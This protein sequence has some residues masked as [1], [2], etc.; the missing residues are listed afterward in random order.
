MNKDELMID[1]IAA[2]LGELSDAAISAASKALPQLTNGGFVNAVFA[3]GIT[4]ISSKTKERLCGEKNELEKLVEI[5]INA[6]KVP[7]ESQNWCKLQIVDLYTNN[8]IEAEKL[9]NNKNYKKSYVQKLSSLYEG[10]E[11]E[12]VMSVSLHVFESLSIAIRNTPS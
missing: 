5:C 11:K 4:I 7:N 1:S 8:P 12:I 3:V 9:I 10:G 6:C 2:A